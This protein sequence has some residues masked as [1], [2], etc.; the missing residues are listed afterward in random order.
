MRLKYD[1]NIR[2]NFIVRLNNKGT[3]N[4]ESESAIKMSFKSTQNCNQLHFIKKDKCLWDKNM[5]ANSP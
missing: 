1:P 5:I 2:F 4:T 3:P